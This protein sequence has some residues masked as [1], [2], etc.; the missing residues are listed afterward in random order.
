MAIFATPGFEQA[1]L[2]VPRQ[3]LREG[4]VP[5]R[6]RLARGERNTWVGSKGWGRPVKLD[7]TLDAARA[8]D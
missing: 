1:E 4:R 3:R 2:E 6:R 5:G 8:E 7:L